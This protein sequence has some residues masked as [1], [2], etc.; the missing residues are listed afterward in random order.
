[1]SRG[2]VYGKHA[3]LALTF[4]TCLP[5]YSNCKHQPTASSEFVRTSSPILLQRCFAVSPFTVGKF[6]LISQNTAVSIVCGRKMRTPLLNRLTK[7]VHY[8]TDMTGMR[9]YPSLEL[10]SVALIFG[11]NSSLLF[12]LLHFDY[13]SRYHVTYDHTLFKELNV[14]MPRH[15]EFLER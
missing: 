1:M 8:E 2:G 7:R 9:R 3:L 14:R 13:Y 10:L 4:C 6:L 12:L 5:N 11:A 15:L